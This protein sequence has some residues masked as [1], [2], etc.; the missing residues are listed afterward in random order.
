MDVVMLLHLILY[1][2]TATIASP[3]L[4]ELQR[5]N[6]GVTIVVAKETADASRRFV[7]SSERL[8]LGVPLEVEF[9]ETQ[10]SGDED[11]IVAQNVS[12]PGAKY[13]ITIW[14]TNGASFSTDP[15]TIS[16]TLLN[17]TGEQN[18]MPRNN[19]LIIYTLLFCDG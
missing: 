9:E 5:A 6:S 18:G 4:S 13:N 16:E 1:H 7:S 11:D 2:Y 3:V 19:T 8:D 12:V 17:D 14:S 10:S 15:L